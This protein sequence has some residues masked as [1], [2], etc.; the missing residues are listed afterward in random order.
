[1]FY[2][3]CLCGVDK[4]KY[5]KSCD[6]RDQE[7]LGLVPFVKW[8]F[9]CNTGAVHGLIFWLFFGVVVSATL[10]PWPNF[11]GLLIV[12][13][14]LLSGYLDFVYPKFSSIFH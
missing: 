12:V 4:E 13:T 11:L 10:G 7:L 1:M 6:A 14:N 8:L 2:N 3:F 5:T 9:A